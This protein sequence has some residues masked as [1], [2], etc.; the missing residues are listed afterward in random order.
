MTALIPGAGPPP[1][2]IASVFT[3]PLGLSYATR[4]CRPNRPRASARRL[5]HAAHRLAEPERARQGHRHLQRGLE[6]PGPGPALDQRAREAGA[7]AVAVREQV[8]EAA[9]DVARLRAVGGGHDA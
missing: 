4:Q 2:R 9:D 7:V 3:R 8:A 6:H 5:D 1:T